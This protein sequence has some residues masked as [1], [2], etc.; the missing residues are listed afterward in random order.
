[1]ED[2]RVVAQTHTLRLMVE[3]AKDAGLSLFLLFIDLTQAFDSV[4]LPSVGRRAV[5][6]IKHH[7]TI[8]LPT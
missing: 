8:K 7:S 4:R 5:A 3:H 2:A 6:L 1:M